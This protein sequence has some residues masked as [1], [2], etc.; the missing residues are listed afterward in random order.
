[1]QVMRGFE[2]NQKTLQ[3]Q[4]QILRKAANELGKVR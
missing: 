1:M 2:A 3:T 4:D